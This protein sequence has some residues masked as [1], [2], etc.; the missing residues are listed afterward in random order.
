MRKHQGASNAPETRNV[1]ETV[2]EPCLLH[3]PEVGCSC[4]LRINHVLG[5]DH[6]VAGHAKGGVCN[7]AR[8]PHF[9]CVA[10]NPAHSY[11]EGL[12]TTMAVARKYTRAAR[13]SGPAPTLQAR[14]AAPAQPAGQAAALTP[15]Q[16]M[17]L[18]LQR[19]AGNAAVNAL[20]RQQAGAG[21]GAVAARS[22]QR[23]VRAG[24]APVTVQRWPSN[25]P[26]LNWNNTQRITTITSGQ[27]VLFFHDATEPPV[28]V[29]AEDAPYGITQLTSMMHEQVHG[30]PTISTRDGTASKGTFLNLMLDAGKSDDSWAKLGNA[31]QG[32]SWIVPR[33]E[34]TYVSGKNDQVETKGNTPAEK[35]RYFMADQFK[36][37]PKIQIMAVAPG[38]SARALAGKDAKSG[39]ATA[40]P[41]AIRNLF[42]DAGYVRQLGQLTAADLFVENADRV[43][44]N[45]GN[46]MTD[47][48]MGI[49]LIDNM[50]SATKNLWNGKNDPSAVGDTSMLSQLATGSRKK[51]LDTLI[52]NLERE[53]SN[54]GGDLNAWLQE[55]KGAGTREEAIRKSLSEGLDAGKARIISLYATGKMG[56][57]GRAAKKAAK[58]A[59]KLDVKSGDQSKNVPNYWERLKARARYLQKQ[60]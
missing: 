52:R 37:L 6:R 21:Q 46:W 50:D 47:A 3:D 19:T 18:Q 27:P 16:S 32:D 29:K 30:T 20:L 4:I 33:V 40:K 44:Y 1:R 9:R 39:G 58:A 17:I 48:G 8:P 35:A 11:K 25:T 5:A 24:G 60:G 41:N 26:T 7:A 59:H 45:F 57:A 31:K 12:I 55:A 28:V 13:R 38:K 22:V 36:S 14:K 15:T 54:F 23:R 42:D 34:Y 51:L 43:M 53:V 56:K 10:A 2:C 49:T